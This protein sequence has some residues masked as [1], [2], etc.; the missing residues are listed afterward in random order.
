MDEQLQ[1]YLM[2]F[3]E[4][5][6]DWAVRLESLAAEERVPIMEPLGIDY[7]RQLI[8]I[9]KPKKILEIGAAIGYSALMMADAYP[10][11]KVFTVERDRQRYEQAVHHIETQNKQDQIKVFLGDA[12]ESTN[13]IGQ[14]GP[15]DF[16]FIDAAKGQYRRFFDLYSNF[17]ADEGVIVSDNVLFKGLVASQETAVNKRLSSVA[18][19]LNGYN[20]WL[21]E[22]PDYH[23]TIVPI[24]DGVAVSVK[25]IITG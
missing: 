16:L 18:E 5:R 20:E 14:Y 4:K 13:E 24:G 8:R 17:L 22:H 23:T 19:K 1:N 15:Y 9:K 7:V 3:K 6:P 25:K 10:E 21:K 11:T 12:L 2:S